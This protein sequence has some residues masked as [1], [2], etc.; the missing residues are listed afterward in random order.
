MLRVRVS[1]R[2][3]EVIGGEDGSVASALV[4]GTR[5]G[6]SEKTND[7]LR[8][9]GL[10]HILSI[11]G[12]HMALAAG[13]V[14]LTLRSLFALFPAFSVRHPVKNM[15]PFSLLSC[16]FYLAMSGADV[17]AQRS[18]VMIAVMLGA[19]LVDRAAIS[20]RNLAI[21]A[22]AMI[23]ISPHEILGPSFQM[24]FSATA[25][26]IADMRGGASVM[27]ENMSARKGVESP[28]IVSGKN[29]EAGHCGGGYFARRGIGERNFCR[30]S[31]Q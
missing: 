2:I 18:Y 1:E 19:L 20:M 30:L 22:L 23:A 21:A 15:Q 11:S 14:M 8:K 31:F 28:L 24:S 9:A 26:L 17:A 10:A 7:D 6:I 12:L 16:T 25:A 29:P 4:A 13:V 5:A 3:E 27:Q